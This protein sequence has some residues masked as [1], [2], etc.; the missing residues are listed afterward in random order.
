MYD[1]ELVLEVLSQIYQSTQKIIRRCERLEYADA[2][3]F[4]EETVV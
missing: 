4:I 3:R 2:E 1:R